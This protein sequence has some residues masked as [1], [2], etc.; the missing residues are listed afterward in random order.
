MKVNHEKKLIFIHIPKCAGT[1]VGNMLDL[2]LHDGCQH[3]MG[4][5]SSREGC[6]FWHDYTKFAIVRNPWEAAL[7]HFFDRLTSITDQ[8][9][10][11]ALAAS[12]QRRGHLAHAVG[13]FAHSIKKPICDWYWL[14]KNAARVR[15]VN[16]RSIMNK[17]YRFPLACLKYSQSMMRYL[18][19]NKDSN[20]FMVDKIVRFEN[21]EQQLKDFTESVG[22]GCQELKHDN[23]TMHLHYSKYYTKQW[24]IDYIY[25]THKDYI[26]YFNYEFETGS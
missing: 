15:R 6:D 13:G 11:Q 17:R 14:E 10:T 1:S 26:K 7:S 24:M 16:R 3:H 18:T 5:S 2:K 12:R 23:K 8:N 22:A 9:P 21:L 25:D 20:K 19:S 4:A